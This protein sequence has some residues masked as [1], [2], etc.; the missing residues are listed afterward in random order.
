MNQLLDP[1]ISHNHLLRALVVTRLVTARR[2]T[3]G[4]H[5]IA[6]A[7]SLSFAT[8]VRMVHRVHR[9]AAHMRPNSLPAGATRFAERNVF[10]LDVPD[11]TYRRATLNRDAPDFPGRHTQLCIS[12]FFGQQL[13]ERS[14]R[15]GHLPTFPG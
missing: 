4:R 3:P 1:P 9:H 5:G 8:S 7:R 13:G 11:L 6:A 14:G 10:M 2:L 15:A 12:A